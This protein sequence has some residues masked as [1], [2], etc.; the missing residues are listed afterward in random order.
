VVGTATAFVFSASTVTVQSPQQNEALGRLVGPTVDA[1]HQ[2]QREGKAGP[3]LLT[4]FPDPLGIGAQGYG[5]LNELD[6]RGFDVRVDPVNRPGAT[7][8]RVLEHTTPKTTEIHIAVGPDIRR[9]QRSP[10]Y[11]QVAYADPRPPAARAEV[12]RLEAQIARELQQAGVPN[13]TRS[14]NENLFML[15]L[16][17]TVPDSARQ[18]ISRVLDLGLPAAV[19]IGPPSGLGHP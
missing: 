7:R 16:D 14:I 6:R 5:L 17:Q 9:W 2:L 3:Y 18:Q 8:Y 19:F 4:F 1:L 10:D 13:I 12:A 15:G 11:R